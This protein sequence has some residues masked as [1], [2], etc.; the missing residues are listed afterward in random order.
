MTYEDMM[1]KYSDGSMTTSQWN[2]TEQNDLED[3]WENFKMKLKV[4]VNRLNDY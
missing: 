1:N 4:K 3:A 2:T